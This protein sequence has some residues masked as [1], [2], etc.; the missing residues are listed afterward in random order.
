MFEFG[1]KM[2]A[3]ENRSVIK[4]YFLLGKSADETFNNMKIVYKENCPSKATP[5]YDVHV[6]VTAVQKPPRRCCRKVNLDVQPRSL[7][8]RPKSARRPSVNRRIKMDELAKALNISKGS[9]V[10]MLSNYR[11]I[12]SSPTDLCPKFCLQK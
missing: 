2:A 12:G 10:T 11:V 9:A 3:V 6:L 5:Y 1:S 4:F 7:T 8:T